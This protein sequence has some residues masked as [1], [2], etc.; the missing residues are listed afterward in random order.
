MGLFL[1][2]GNTA[3]FT[4]DPNFAR[5]DKDKTHP[6]QALRNLDIRLK[7]IVIVSLLRNHA[8]STCCSCGPVTTASGRKK[9]LR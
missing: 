2:P 3:I 5:C 8:P 4:V 1:P 9:K 7:N 6:H